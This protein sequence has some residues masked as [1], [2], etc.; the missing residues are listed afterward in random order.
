M[1]KVDEKNSLEQFLIK[2]KKTFEGNKSAA[3]QY[4][5]IVILAIVVVAM[6]R[7]KFFSGAS[8]KLNAA[9]SAYYQATLSS[10]SGSGVADGQTLLNAASAY[11]NKVTGDVLN[12]EAGDAFLTAGQNDVQA[13][14]SYSRGVKTSDGENKA[15]ADPSV[16]FNAAYDAYQAAA[17]SSD[18]EVRARAYYG[19]GVA[20]E[21]L[22]SVA[23]SDADV[24]AAIEKAK[25]SYKKVAEASKDSP[26]CDLA[27]KALQNLDRAL[28]IEFYK[29]VADKFRNLPE[30]SDESIL[31]GNGDELNVGEQIDVS[32]FETNDDSGEED[33]KEPQADDPAP[34][35]E[36]ASAEAA[37]AESTE[38]PA[39][40]TA[41]PEN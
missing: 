29:S 20:Q 24:E 10:F 4:I 11:K 33:V 23:A 39:E 25:E 8:G 32:G 28:T 19:A 6:V 1:K 5:L 7:V 37:P 2:S 27:T 17:K 3:F 21:S 13:K 34:A 9:D 16:N 26:Y 30:P 15:P 22:A 18:L 41:A 12:A 36:A 14:R 35:E 38:T 40:E 31:S